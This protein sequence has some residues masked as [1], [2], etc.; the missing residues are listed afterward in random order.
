MFNQIVDEI[1][2]YVSE[3]K[4]V[5]NEIKEIDISLSCAYLVVYHNYIK[6]Q[7]SNQ[8]KVIGGRN[9]IVERFTQNFVDND[10]EFIKEDT[11]K[12]ITGPNMA[13]K[14][15]FLRQVALISLLAQC[16]IPVPAKSAELKIYDSIYFLL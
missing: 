13:G 3:I 7:F 2:N 1:S 11:C 14:S 6:P 12:I 10:Y 8:T 9:P 16:G 5:I 15:T 4:S